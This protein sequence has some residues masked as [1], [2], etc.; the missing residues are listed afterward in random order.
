METMV[1]VEGLTVQELLEM[2]RRF[3]GNAFSFEYSGNT[4]KITVENLVDELL[5]YKSLL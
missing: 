2:K 3:G 4:V 5:K 1:N